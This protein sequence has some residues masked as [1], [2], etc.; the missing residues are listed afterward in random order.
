VRT[1]ELECV[2]CKSSA[3]LEGGGLVFASQHPEFTREGSRRHMEKLLF[4]KEEFESIKVQLKEI[5]DR[6]RGGDWLRPGM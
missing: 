4:E 6:Y 1:E 5:R 3:R 2:I